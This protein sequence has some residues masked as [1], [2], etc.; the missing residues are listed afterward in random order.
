MKTAESGRHGT[1]IVLTGPPGAGKSTVAATV[2]RRFAHAVHL[3][4][5]DYWHAI[6]A[7]AIPPYEPESD[8]QN[9][10]VLRVISAAAFEFAAG[11][12]TTVVD[13]IIGPWMLDHLRARLDAAPRIPVH[14]VVLRPNRDVALARATGRTTS[15]ALTDRAPIVALWDQFAD[16]GAFERHAIDTSHDD[17]AGSIERVLNAVECKRFRLWVH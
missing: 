15:G 17:A 11:G 6:V 2:A 9:H 7:G 8:A 13:G 14:Y 3:H 12:F 4:T 16:L 5:D 10:T 1:V